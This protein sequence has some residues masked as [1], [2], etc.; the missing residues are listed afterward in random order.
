MIG[1]LK[2]CRVV[3]HTNQA[4]KTA[5]RVHQVFL[6]GQLFLFVCAFR[7]DQNEEAAKYSNTEK[8]ICK[9]LERIHDFTVEK[10]LFERA[11]KDQLSTRSSE[12]PN[13]CCTETCFYIVP[14][15]WLFLRGNLHLLIKRGGTSQI[16]IAPGPPCRG[17][18][19]QLQSGSEPEAKT[20]CL[21]GSK[22]CTNTAHCCVQRPGLT[23]GKGSKR[24]Q[25][26]PQDQIRWG[27][28]GDQTAPDVRP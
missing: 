13:C 7:R 11:V 17:G 8:Q 25:A 28:T 21:R 24:V 20:S 23:Y 26:P 9:D 15:V 18:D 27:V 6:C 16:Q 22:P 1:S 2:D 19:R 3:D 12:R 10:I 14:P 5:T 4:D